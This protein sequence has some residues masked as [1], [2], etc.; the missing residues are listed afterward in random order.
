MRLEIAC[1]ALA[2]LLA[3]G[4]EDEP[5]PHAWA[6]LAFREAEVAALTDAGTLW[7]ISL[8]GPI[9]FA[10]P[11]T[12]TVV[13]NQPDEA[14]QL[15]ERNG[16]FVGTLPE[17]V[18]I[19]NTGCDWGGVRWTMVMWPL[20]DDRHARVRLLL[21]ESFHRIQPQLA[22]GGGD[23]LSLHLDTES[24]RTWLRLEF[25]ALA[26]ALVQGGEA[27]KRASSDALLFR[28]RRRALFPD[29]RDK[30]AAFERNEGL[31]EYTGL[32]LCGLPDA[33]LADRAAQK[34]EQDE[35]AASFVR[36]FAYATGPAY[37]LLLDENGVTWRK[38]LDSS[39]DLAEILAR[40]TGWS[41]PESLTAEADRRAASYDRELVAAAE[42]RR[43]EERAR[44]EARNRARYVEGPV[45]ALPFGAELNYSFDFH[46][47]TPLDGIGSVYGE[48]RVVDAWGVLD[49]SQGGAL[50]VQTPKGAL[51]GARV[52]APDEPMARPLRGE[53]WTLELAPG[54][55]L[56]GDERDGD[57]KVVRAR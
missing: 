46:R 44:V 45:L 16:V 36:S 18:P 30:E 3:T 47:I 29:A 11:V 27:R 21:H 2:L 24:G 25:R 48:V 13:A 34:L 55:T 23:T 12:R 10:D 42:R 22:H 1:A 43:A 38:G 8:V 17:R 32:K 9:L 52:P 37:G 35:S 28:A 56:E 33:V 31:A 15:A 26:A 49:A 4:S 20:P 5:I 41:V 6:A 53:G 50:F 51:I 7:G 40:S 57:W 39:A 54:W 19:A 14:D